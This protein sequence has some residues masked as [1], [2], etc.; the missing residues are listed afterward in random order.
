MANVIVF[1]LF[2]VLELVKAVQCPKDALDAGGGC[3]ALD[4]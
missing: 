3:D 4:I 1:K 2:D